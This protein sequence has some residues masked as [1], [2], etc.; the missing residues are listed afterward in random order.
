MQLGA[1]RVA[2]GLVA[3]LLLAT[4]GAAQAPLAADTVLVVDRIVAVVGT[5]P[6][7]ASQVDEAL[8]TRFPQGLPTDPE[9]LRSARREQLESLIEAELMV[10]EAERDTTIKVSSEQVQE[11]VEQTFRNAR[12]RYPSEAAFRQDLAN[13]GFNTPEEYRSWLLEEQRRTLL[14]QSLEAARQAQGKIR[15]VNPTEAE[16]R[17]FFERQRP[18]LQPRPPLVSFRQVVV[19]PRATAQ[20]K[21]VTRALGD[22]IAAELRRGADFATAA[23]RFSQDPG[24]REQGGEL[25]WF[26]RG[27]MVQE[28]EEVAFNFRPGFISDPV[29]SPF[30]FHIIQVQRVQPAEVKARH[31]L[32]RPEIGQ[33]QA[34]SARVLAE[35]L[36][37]ALVAGASLDSII[38]LHHDR[39]GQTDFTQITESNLPQPYLE[40]L[41]GVRPGEVAPVVVLPDADPAQSRYAVVRLT[42]RT[43][44]G[45]P[46]FED[47]VGLLRGEL[48]RQIGV[49]RYLD[50]LRNSTYIE[51]REP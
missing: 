31:I 15:S 36:R 46:R 41:E 30:G 7:L 51:I 37:S 22:S 38:R 24:S 42:N 20:A 13:A 39:S 43:P 34:D 5:R 33:E 11:S 44:G 23:R 4:P 29:E 14:I 8:F 1:R 32:L 6:I 16:L 19:S 35:R 48:A 10:L 26:R 25:D 28:F 2:L 49:R 45:E 17:A 21:A 50:T 18:H 27:T 12:A 47:V 9:V 3:G 40:A